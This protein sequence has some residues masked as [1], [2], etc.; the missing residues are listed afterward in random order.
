MMVR[1]EIRCPSQPRHHVS[2][3]IVPGGVGRP[4]DIVDSPW[5]LVTYAVSNIRDRSAV[6]RLIRVFLPERGD[7]KK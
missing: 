6:L 1:R 3:A 5:D 2:N 4:L 7:N